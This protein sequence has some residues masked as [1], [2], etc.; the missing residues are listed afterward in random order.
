MAA[1][2]SYCRSLMALKMDCEQYCTANGSGLLI[3]PLIN[4]FPDGLRAVLL[5]RQERIAHSS[6]RQQL[7]RWFACRIV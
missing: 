2:F 1:G 5:C 3:P 4:G 6:A 7:S